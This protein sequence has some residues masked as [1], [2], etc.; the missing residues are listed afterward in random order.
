MIDWFEYER[1]KAEL[2][3]KKLTSAEYEKEI[4]KIVEELEVENDK[5]NY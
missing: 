2:R 4:K 3:E 5:V 1:L